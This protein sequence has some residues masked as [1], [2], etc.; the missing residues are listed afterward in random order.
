MRCFFVTLFLLLAHCNS[1]HAATI[2][3]ASVSRVD[4]GSAVAA[5]SDGDTVQIPSGSACWTNYLIIYKAIT[6]RGAGTNLTWIYD[7]AYS[8]ST[9]TGV[10]QFDLPAGKSGRITALTL[11][12]T[13]TMTDAGDQH[14]ALQFVGA[15]QSF[16]ADHLLFY[17]L[18]N[19]GMV[20]SGAACG[21]TDHNDFNM[22]NWQPI[23]VTHSTW[24]GQL[25]GDGSWSSAVDWGSTNMVVIENNRFWGGSSGMLSMCD[26]LQG[27]RFCF[28]YN[29]VTNGGVHYH[30]T[31]SGGRLRSTRAVEIYGNRIVCTNASPVI[32]AMD[33]RGGTGVIYSNTFINQSVIGSV[34]VDLLV[35]PF[36]Y[37]GGANGTNA[38][39]SNN[40]TGLYESNVCSAGG[41]ATFTRA[42]AGWTPNQWAGYCVQAPDHVNWNGYGVTAFAQVLSNTATAMYLFEWNNPGGG[43]GSNVFFVAGD[44]Y[45]IY[46]VE[47]VIDQLGRGQGDLLS[48]DPPTPSAWPNQAL[49]PV[50]EWANT[51]DGSPADISTIYCTAREGVELLSD[52]VKP[53]YAPLSYPHPLVVAQDGNAT[54]PP[55]IHRR[56]W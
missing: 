27:A 38:W 7:T 8:N 4:V 2:D 10:I 51:L 50:Y 34:T 45:M 47:A 46:K 37:G 19:R 31:D 14:G 52:T 29:D 15:Q 42:G 21:V 33:L 12:G 11:A 41:S 36:W 39:H 25:Y 35:A 1:L 56:R 18:F 16:R 53:G 3:S 23:Y 55:V 44:R 43:G 9:R 32:Y 20:I 54:R 40:V 13:N 22:T 49:E 17:R 48:G 26:G 5:A 28:R 24:G 6:L 30:G